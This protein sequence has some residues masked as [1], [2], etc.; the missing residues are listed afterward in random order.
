MAELASR[1]FGTIA[2]RQLLAAGFARSRVDRWLRDGR[3][4]RRYPG[5]YAWGRPELPPEGELAA[6]LLFAGHGSALTGLS[7]LWWLELLGR[8]P[9][10]MDIDAPGRGRIHRHLLIR[11]PAEIERRFHR[12]L[13]IAALPRC[14]LLAGELLR[15][16]SLRLVLARAEFRRHLD[17]RALQSALE[18]GPRG[19]RAL[20]AAM[21]AHLPQLALCAN[22][23]ERR[24]VLLCE[25]HGLEIPE[26]N[27]R[28]GRYRPDMLW[29]SRR[30]VV[31]L[32]GEDA[33][34]TAA[35]FAAD[36][37]RQSYLESLGFTVLRFTWAEVEFMPERVVAITRAH[38]GGS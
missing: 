33:H 29:R 35:Q 27:A 15:H 16:D 14:L 24:F 20:R 32:D 31:E 12:G 8:R 23:F 19:A 1:Q 26:P 6:G 28:I 17:L 22:G 34:S 38:L 2:R 5:V 10:R 9:D 4:H 3:L 25:S 13:P 7:A 30:L 11:H 18:Q 21:D 37:R 36:A